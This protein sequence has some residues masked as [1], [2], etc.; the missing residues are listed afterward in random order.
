MFQERFDAFRS[1]FIAPL[2]TEGDTEGIFIE[3]HRA[4]LRPGKISLQRD[5]T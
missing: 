4:Q 1:E 3:G 2:F 5:D